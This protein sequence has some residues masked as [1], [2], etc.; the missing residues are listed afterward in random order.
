MAR[1][2]KAKPAQNEAPVNQ[3]CADTTSVVESTSDD[4]AVPESQTEGNEMTDSDVPEGYT[5]TMNPTAPAEKS[6]QDLAAEKQLAKMAAKAA[7]AEAKAVKDAEK[8][9]KAAEKAAMSNA[10]KEERAA[11]HAARAERLAELN[12]DGTRKYTGSMLSLADR[13]K[14]GAYVKGA[15]GQLRTNDDLAN[16]LD[17]VPVMNVI[18]LAKIV[19]ELDANPYSHLNTGQQ[20]MN[21]R[22]KMRGAITKGTLTLDRI[23][24]VIEE[25]GFATAT[26]WA[27]LKEEKKAKREAAA[28]A[29]KAEKEA[30]AAAKA[31]AKANEPETEPA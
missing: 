21:L 20:S 26:D 4:G 10:T 24:E 31:A 16:A 8:A 1:T 5:H 11:A 23:K 14:Q 29:A 28:A 17:A 30:K 12:A 9:A 2:K 27:A 13:V 22:N 7:K 18:A 25:Q 15:T 3:D 19:L 6:K